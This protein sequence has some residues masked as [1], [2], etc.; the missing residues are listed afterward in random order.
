M[1]GLEL[2]PLLGLGGASAGAGAAASAGAASAGATGLT[3]GQALGLAGT[4]ISA[5]GT[6]AAGQAAAN[7]AKAEANQMEL[8]ADEERAAA[9]RDALQRRREGRLVQSRQQAVAAA[10]G[11]G[12]GM[13]APT[14]VKLMTDTA[15]QAD[16]NA[17]V[18]MYGGE[19]RSRGLLDSARARRRS[20][21]ASLL[22]STIG[23]FGQ[24]GT[25]FGKVFA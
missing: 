2:L 22:G 16:Y 11:G 20:G 15:G 17:R 24:A 3:L 5:A 21:K 10:S 13:D 23:A 25:G 9:Q 7:E 4:G 18:S 12:A 19:S 1:S 8:K 6:Y 14:I